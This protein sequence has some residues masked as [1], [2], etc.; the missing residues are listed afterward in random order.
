MSLAKLSLGGKND[1]IYK[2]FLPRECL[3][4][5]IPAGNGNIEKLFLRCTRIQIQI[6]CERY[7][8][9]FTVMGK[10]TNKNPL[11]DHIL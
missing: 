2:L 9:C 5:D 1:V 7:D 10:K 11:G 6:S 4:S 3:V 8:R